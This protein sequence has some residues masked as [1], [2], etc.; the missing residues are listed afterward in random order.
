MHRRIPAWKL[1]LCAEVLNASPADL[2]RIAELTE[3]QFAT[4]ERL[5]WQLNVSLR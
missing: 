2:T 5:T 3:I 4:V 1:K